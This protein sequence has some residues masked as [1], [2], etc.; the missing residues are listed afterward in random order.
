M[1]DITLP[2]APMWV[3]MVDYSIRILTLS[4]VLSLLVAAMLFFGLQRMIVRPLRRI[5]GEIAAF[6]S[7]P[8]DGT[9]DREP[10]PR[11]DEIGVVEGELATMRAGLRSALAE[12]T[13]LAA[14]GAGMSRIGHD[15]RNILATAVLISDR[16]EGSADPAVR[17]VAPRLRGDPGPRRAAV[18]RDAELCPHRPAGA[19][20]APGLA[21]RAGGKGARATLDAARAGVAWRLAVPADLVVEADPDQLFRVLFNLAQNAIEAMGERGGELRIAAE[22][23]PTVSRDRRGRHRAGHSRAGAQQAVRAVR[24][25]VEG[26][27]QRPGARDL[28]RADARAWRRDRAARNLRARHDLPPSPAGAPCAAGRRP[29]RRT[30]MPLETVARLVLPL[31][32]LLGGCDYQGPAVA[33]Y[34]GLQNKIQWY[35]DSNALEQNATCTQPRMRS[36]T[37]AQIIDETP[38][39]VVMNIRYYWL[40]EGQ[41]D[42]DRGGLPLARH[43]LPAL[44]RLR[45]AAFHLRQ[46]DRRQPGRAQHDRAAAAAVELSA[47]P[48]RNASCRRKMRSVR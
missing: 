45:R 42:F 1:V 21:G 40:D 19:A 14:L 5:T 46:D 25:L 43:L 8:E 6:R 24:R 13:R 17:R 44:Q 47:Q 12:K 3:A 38:E 27:R 2:E 33:G 30:P 11:A 28:P 20:A 37:G 23:T 9:V 16:L 34:P 26:G 7:R 31:A 41:L 36:V 22:L 32:L 39:T 10:E 15:L 4:I 48:S 29:A 18:R 35:Y